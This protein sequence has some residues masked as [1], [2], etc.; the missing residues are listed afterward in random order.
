VTVQNY[1][2]T[3]PDEDYLEVFDRVLAHLE[4]GLPL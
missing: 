3:H 1:T 2:F 4:A